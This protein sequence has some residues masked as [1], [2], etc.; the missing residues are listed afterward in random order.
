MY[1]IFSLQLCC[2]KIHS[3][4]IQSRH[5]VTFFWLLW[6]Y[7]QLGNC[8]VLTLP[9]TVPAI[10]I[11]LCTI[12]LSYH[13]QSCVLAITLLCFYPTARTMAPKSVCGGLGGGGWSRVLWGVRSQFQR[14][15]HLQGGCTFILL[16]KLYVYKDEY[17]NLFLLRWI[18]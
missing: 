15:I 8:L 14:H 18:K 1:F 10:E 5:E 12:K 17:F 4:T 6:F 16:L 7:P 11:M 13:W 9:Q 3:T 2:K